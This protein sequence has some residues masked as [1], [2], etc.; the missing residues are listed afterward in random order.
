MGQWAKKFTYNLK[1]TNSFRYLK[2]FLRE[3]SKPLEAILFQLLIWIDFS[4]IISHNTVTKEGDK[5]LK[6]K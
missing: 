2:P 3:H 6:C 1:S 5:E 4:S